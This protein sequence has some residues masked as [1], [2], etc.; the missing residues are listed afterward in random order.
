MS[1]VND[2]RATAPNGQR[3]RTARPED[4]TSMAQA[5]AATFYDDAVFRHFCPDDDRRA[6]MLPEFFGV[7]VEAY[8]THGDAYADAGGARAAL[9]AYRVTTRSAPTRRTAS[10]SRRS[11]VSTRP[12]SSRS[13]RPSSRKPR[14]SPITTSSSSASGRSGRARALEA[15]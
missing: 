11:P 1:L 4:A 13:S 5:L 2:E 3:V 10:G 12:G 9:W 15:P 6:A 7:F 14:R 8:L